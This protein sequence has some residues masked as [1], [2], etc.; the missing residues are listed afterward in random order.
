[1][2]NIIHFHDLPQGFV[3]VL[4]QTL[5]GPMGTKLGAFALTGASFSAQFV[6]VATLPMFSADPESVL[7][8]CSL[9]AGHGWPLLEAKKVLSVDRQALHVHLVRR[10]KSL[11]AALPVYGTPPVVRRGGFI[12]LLDS[13][14][15]SALSFLLG[16]VCCRLGT[17]A[18]ASTKGPHPLTSFW[19]FKLAL[20]AAACLAEASDVNFPDAENPDYI[21]ET[22]QGWF[23]A[24]AKGSWDGMKWQ[25]LEDGLWQASKFATLQFADPITGAFVPEP[26]EACTCTRA[27]FYKG[28]LRLT[29]VDPPRVGRA[30]PLACVRSFVDLVRFEQAFAQFDAHGYSIEA[31]DAVP[32]YLLNTEMSWRVWRNAGDDSPPIHLGM[33]TA[34][35]ECRAAVEQTLRA[36]RTLVPLCRVSPRTN[37]EEGLTGLIDAGALQA[38]LAEHIEADIWRN[39]L[40]GRARA[41]DARRVAQAGLYANNISRGAL[42][43]ALATQPMVAGY[44]NALELARHLNQLARWLYEE[45][46]LAARLSQVRQPDALQLLPCLNGMVV[47]H[48]RWAEP[49]PRPDLPKSRTG[50]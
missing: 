14:E 36:L 49:Q 13:S 12:D 24:E 17:A 5:I 39:D 3:P 20:D 18:W 22:A 43:H 28:E 31:G 29:H 9:D 42:L 32:A 30:P 25:D 23:T 7:L 16:A 11:M 4:G 47:C 6:E 46:S 41:W 2:P 26:I 33:P 8:A 48:G 34:M 15:Q 21:F 19:H 37:V 10:F 27:D 1:M 35:L 44:A 45:G 40:L 38:A 50:I